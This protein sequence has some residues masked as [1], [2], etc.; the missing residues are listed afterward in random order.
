MTHKWLTLS[1]DQAR[2]K[3]IEIWLSGKS[4]ADVDLVRVLQGHTFEDVREFIHYVTKGEQNK[5]MNELESFCE[6]FINSNPQIVR[7]FIKEQDEEN[8]PDESH[9]DDP[10]RGQAEEINE[11]RYLIAEAI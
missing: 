8:A 7:W 3:L 5:A 6:D 1:E 11:R 9:L 4:Y 2:E 10:R